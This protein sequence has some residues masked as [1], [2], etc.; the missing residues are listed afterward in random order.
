MCC[1]IAAQC[2]FALRTWPHL[3]NQVAEG[4]IH[5][6]QALGFLLTKQRSL[7]KKGCMGRFVMVWLGSNVVYVRCHTAHALVSVCGCSSVVA[8]L[9][10]QGVGGAGE[11]CGPISCVTHQP[12][13]LCSTPYAFTS[14][15]CFDNASALT[16]F[17]C[18]FPSTQD[19][20][21]QQTQLHQCRAERHAVFAQRALGATLFIQFPG[22]RSQDTVSVLQRD[23][24]A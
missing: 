21:S 22:S 5:V 16:Y 11:A 18:Q 6:V 12:L 10:T 17:S 1:A 24:Q 23:N 14:A 9:A 4:G 3:W 2:L 20:G 7:L 15:G 19:Q 13:L 8:A